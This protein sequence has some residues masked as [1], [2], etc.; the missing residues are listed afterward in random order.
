MEDMHSGK[1]HGKPI[2]PGLD[3][4]ARK[5]IKDDAAMAFQYMFIRVSDCEIA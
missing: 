2:T 5:M 1:Y 4:E 3:N